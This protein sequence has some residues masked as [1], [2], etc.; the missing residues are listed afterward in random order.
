MGHERGQHHPTAI[1]YVSSKC[2]ESAPFPRGD[3]ATALTVLKDGGKG[4]SKIP[5]SELKLNKFMTS[6]I[7]PQ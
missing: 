1:P 4:K 7:S 5:V 3:V 6:C 2:L